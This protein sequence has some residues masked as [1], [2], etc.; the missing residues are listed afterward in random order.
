MISELR[1]EEQFE[2][3]IFRED[4]RQL[5]INTM[6]ALDYISVCIDII[7]NTMLSAVVADKVVQLRVNVSLFMKGH[8]ALSNEVDLQISR[9]AESLALL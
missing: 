5:L 4:V 2:L 9:I 1:E 3:E 8:N 6:K 7:S